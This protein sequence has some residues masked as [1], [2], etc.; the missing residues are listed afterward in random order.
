MRRRPA[1]KRIARAHVDDDRADRRHRRPRAPADRRPLRHA[2]RRPAFRPD[3][4]TDRAARCRAARADP[5]G[6]R[7][8]A[9]RAA[10]AAAR[11]VACTSSRG[12]RSRS[13]AAAGAPLSQVSSDARGP[14]WKSI[15]RSKRSRAQPAAEREIVEQTAEAAPAWRDDDLVQM[16]IVEDDRRCGRLDDIGQVRVG[17]VLP[18]R[19]WQGW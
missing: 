5:T 11:C 1:S 7:P 6:S 18:Q 10:A 12:R 15:A 9:A 16:G 14:P 2:A 19:G 4:A 17:K 13:R 3:R 8:N